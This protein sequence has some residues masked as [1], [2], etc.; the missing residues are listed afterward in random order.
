MLRVTLLEPA[1]RRVPR[2]KTLYGDYL[3]PMEIVC[4]SLLILGGNSF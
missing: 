4:V 2:K 1:I 3:K